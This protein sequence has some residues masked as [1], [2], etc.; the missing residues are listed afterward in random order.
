MTRDYRK[1]SVI[2]PPHMYGA[3]AKTE[4][5]CAY[6]PL[7]CW[8]H[9]VLECSRVANFD[10]VRRLTIRFLRNGRYLDEVWATLTNESVSP[11][12]RRAALWAVGHVGESETGLAFLE[13]LNAIGYIANLAVT[14][15][16][17]ALRGYIS[18][19]TLP[20]L[21]SPHQ[22]HT[23]LTTFVCFVG[24]RT[25]RASTCWACSLA[26]SGASRS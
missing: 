12:E 19:L 24:A 25:G 10:L 26:Q 3:L 2:P 8:H 13:E 4:K 7:H 21:C 1:K 6:T 18:S 20:A 23:A 11:L 15:D 14:V 9:L 22:W 5:G 16:N 17:L